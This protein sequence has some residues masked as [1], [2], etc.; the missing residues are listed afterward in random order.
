MRA[1]LLILAKDLKLRARDRSVYLFAIVVPLALTAV[2]SLILPDFQTFSMTAAVVDEDGGEVAVG[3]A[4]GVVPALAEEGVLTLAEATDRAEVEALVRD[5]SIDA[6]WVVPA[7]FSSAVL[8][9]QPAELTV[10]VNPDRRLASEVAQGIAEGFVRRVEQVGLAVATSAV[11][12]QGAL[13]PAALEALAGDVAEREPVV[14]VG[15]FDTEIRQLDATTYLAAGMAVFFVFFAVQF[16]VTGLLEERQ[17]HTLPRLLAAPI[18]AVM[19]PIG[20]ALGAA[21]IGVGSLV[22]L[23]VSSTLLLDADWGPPLGVALLILAVVAAALGVMALTG[24]FARTAEQ[25]S[26]FQSIVA[27]LL[28]MLGGVFFPV[29]SDAAVLQ[30]FALIS[31]HGWF[32]RG[33]GEIAGGDVSA[34]LPAVAAMLAFAVVAAI[35]AA[36]RTRRVLS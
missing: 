12:A 11:A 22:V 6:A 20:K 13:D 15:S 10:L 2:F 24:S 1:A 34:A 7:G 17:D 33:L 29:A 23:V 5:G 25:A 3:F 19:I 21:V 28:G 32:L 26:N 31:P 9:G 4:E 8:A 35:P 16:G 14:S 36:L 18:P 27:V 30:A